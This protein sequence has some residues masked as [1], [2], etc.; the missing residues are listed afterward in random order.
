[1]KSS[2]NRFLNGGEEHEEAEAIGCTYISSLLLVPFN[3][4]AS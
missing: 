4:A 2:P 1:M 3:M